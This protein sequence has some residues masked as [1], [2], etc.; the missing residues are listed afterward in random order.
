MEAISLSQ[1]NVS[2]LHISVDGMNLMPVIREVLHDPIDTF[3]IRLM[4]R[5]KPAYSTLC[6][7]RLDID[8][9]SR[10]SALPSPTIAEAQRFAE[11]LRIC[12]SLTQNLTHLS[13]RA[14]HDSFLSKNKAAI[15]RIL[16][17]E[18]HLPRLSH[19]ELGS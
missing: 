7:F 18:L 11:G 19:L 8:L 12:L 17:A 4:D 1:K 3:P 13:L 16:S 2:W 5:I 14:A 10:V 9:F 6:S 15:S